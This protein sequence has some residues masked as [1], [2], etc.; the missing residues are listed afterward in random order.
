MVFLAGD[1]DFVAIAVIQ[2]ADAATAAKRVD[3]SNG[4]W[5]QLRDYLGY[6]LFIE[7]DVLERV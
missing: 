7:I 2:V 3:T 1:Y 5:K 4:V 6:L